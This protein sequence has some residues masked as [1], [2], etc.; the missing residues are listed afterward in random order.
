MQK[1]NHLDAK[2]RKWF[3]IYTRPRAEKKVYEQLQKIGIETYLPLKKELKQWK[4]R[5]KW[6]ETPLFTSYIFVRVKFKEYYE[7]PK[8]IR[9]FVKY[10]TIGG[11]RIAVRDKEIDT[12]KKMLQY[13]TNIEVSN[14]TYKLNEEVEIK[15]GLMKG[16]KGKLINFSGNHKIAIKIET[17][18]SMLIVKINK[19][20]VRK[21]SK[22]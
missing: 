14:E 11:N 18:G 16:L 15:T 13:S 22:Q 21:T 7:I 20:E 1:I 5:K 17:I 2:I 4:D 6:V 12:I 3:A 10:I 9:G 19:N 8:N